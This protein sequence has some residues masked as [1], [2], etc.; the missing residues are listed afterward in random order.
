MFRE[1]FGGR[2]ERKLWE[3]SKEEL[4]E[5]RRKEAENKNKKNEKS[6]YEQQLK[7]N[8]MVELM[9]PKEKIEVN[10]RDF[11][12]MFANATKLAEL[13]AEKKK[14]TPSVNA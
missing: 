10:H 8:L 12:A 2:K 14:E 3:Y 1:G 9:G 4:E 5:K 11:E 7:A 13:F 6:G